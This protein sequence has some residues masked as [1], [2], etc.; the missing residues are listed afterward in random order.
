[1]R[2]ARA[3]SRRRGP[4]LDARSRQFVRG[5]LLAI[6]FPA[7][8]PVLVQIGPLAIRWY[9]LGYIVGILFGWWYARRSS[10]NQ[11]LWGGKRADEARPTSTISWSGRA[12]RRP[13]RPRSATCCS[14][15]LPHYIANPLDI[16]AVWQGGMSFHGGF[17]RRRARHDP[18]RPRPRHP[19]PG[20]VRRHLRRRRLSGCSSAR[21]ANFING[22][23]WGRPTDVPWAFVFPNG[24]PV[25]RHPSQLY[26]AALEGLVLFL[27][28]A[29]LTHRCRHAAAARLRSPAP[30]W[31]ATASRASSCEFFR[32]PDR[33]SA[34]LVGGAHHG[35]GA[36]GCRWCWPASG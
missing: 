13:R 22:E 7:I 17:A 19:D 33:S 12:R 32:E 26:E 5:R 9:A 10:R 30:S 21:I 14:T 25:P 16:F 23:L 28:L 6:A 24:G 20:A 1:M 11:R 34:I 3:A 29:L 36:V 35:H 18:V 8:D 4:A 31:P 27:V 15:I 2:S